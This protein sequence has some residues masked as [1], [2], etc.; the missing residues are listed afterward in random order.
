M[1]RIFKIT[2]VLLAGLLLLGLWGCRK[3]QFTVTATLPKGLTDN[4]VLLYYASDARQ[5][6]LQ[7]QVLVIADGKGE[8]T[9]ATVN[10][11]LVYVFHGAAEPAAI[12]YVEHGDK[13]SI[14]GDNM[15]PLSWRIQGNEITDALTDWRLKNRDILSAHN[16]G[17][18]NASVAKYVAAN[19]E[20]PVST[21]LLLCY[22]DRGEDEAGF[23]KNWKLLKGKAAEPSWSDMVGRNDILTGYHAAAMKAG[24]MI[25][26]VRGGYD[27]VAPSKGG[28]IL[29]YFGNNSTPERDEDIRELK[30]I[31]KER[32]DSSKFLVVAIS[33]EM[34]SSTWKYRVSQDSLKGAV[35]AWMP[36]GLSD[37]LARQL[38]V[39]ALPQALE[40]D[41]LGKVKR[42]AHLKDVTAKK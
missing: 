30:R 42:V 11:A 41:S 40:V 7:D 29:L 34:D 33:C 3:P 28:R 15:N 12:F 37:S 2:V 4:Y 38:G 27:T 21:I 16:A 32:R 1:R 39:T 5:G 17:K 31:L 25:L 8:L 14:K 19:P 26:R 23:V 13:I 24:R 10:P 20:S 22:Y 36:L 9:G 18:I 6:W 35:S